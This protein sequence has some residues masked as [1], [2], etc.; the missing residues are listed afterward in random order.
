MNREKQKKDLCVIESQR[1]VKFSNIYRMKE[2][3]L[4]LTRTTKLR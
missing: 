4:F 1:F 3:F 2:S